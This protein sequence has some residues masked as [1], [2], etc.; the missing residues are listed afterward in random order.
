MPTAAFTGRAERA[1]ERIACPD[2]IVGTLKDPL[3][4]KGSDPLARDRARNGCPWCPPA[5]LFQ[6]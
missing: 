4:Q 1:L 2:T 3:A 5:R 6:R